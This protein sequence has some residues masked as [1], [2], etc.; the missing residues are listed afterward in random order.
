MRPI[1]GLIIRIA[2]SKETVAGEQ[3]IWAT[4]SL[5]R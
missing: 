5:G 3:A 1:G 2:V 4:L